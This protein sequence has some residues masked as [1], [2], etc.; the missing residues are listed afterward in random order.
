MWGLIF[1]T[2]LNLE[3]PIFVMANQNLSANIVGKNHSEFRSAID[4]VGISFSY[5]LLASI[6]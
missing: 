2:H 5:L 1:S 4:L 6:S 3:E